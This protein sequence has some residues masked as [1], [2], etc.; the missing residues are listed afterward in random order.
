MKLKRVGVVSAA[1]VCTWAG[2]LYGAFLGLVYGNL[3]G[4]LLMGLLGLGGA[5]R[6]DM[7]VS[8]WAAVAVCVALCSLLAGLGGLL[9]GLVGSLFFNLVLRITDGLELE[10]D[11]RPAD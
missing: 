2:L 9:H 7:L 6:D 10:V 1:K 5:T 8:H 11:P 3:A 4:G